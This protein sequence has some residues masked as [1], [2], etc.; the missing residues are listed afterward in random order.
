MNTYMQ[1]HVAGLGGALKVPNLLLWENIL[2]PYVLIFII[3]WHLEAS[4]PTPMEI[5]YGTSSVS[6]LYLAIRN[7]FIKKFHD[8]AVIV[9]PEELR[10]LHIHKVLFEQVASAAEDSPGSILPVLG[11]EC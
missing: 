11:H 3:L 5:E 6:K 10:L 1:V 7:A 8:I 4:P 9:F 2:V